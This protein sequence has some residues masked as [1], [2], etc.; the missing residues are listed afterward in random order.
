[1]E[2]NFTSEEEA[3]R[4]LDC[5]PKDLERLVS[6]GLLRSFVFKKQ[7]HYYTDEVEYLANALLTQHGEDE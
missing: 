4:T 2:L 7:V 3:C 6:E 5:S 1:M